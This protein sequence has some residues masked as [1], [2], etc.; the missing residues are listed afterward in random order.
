MKTKDLL[1]I[2]ISPAIWISRKKTHIK[3]IRSVFS[4]EI[5]GRFKDGSAVKTFTIDPYQAEGENKVARIDLPDY[6]DDVEVLDGSKYYVKGIRQSGRDNS[7][8]DATSFVV[9]RDM[10]FV[11]AYGLKGRMVRYRVEFV[12]ENG[13][14]LADTQYFEGRKEKSR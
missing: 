13:R 4:L 14:T 10:D 1:V 6:K 8:I 11:V 2:Q 12:D 5:R 9:D 3:P 7:T